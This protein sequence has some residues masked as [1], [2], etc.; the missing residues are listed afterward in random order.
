MVFITNWLN[1]I[2][3]QCISTSNGPVTGNT[4]ISWPLLGLT[5]TWIW[6]LGFH[7]GCCAQNRECLPFMNTCIHSCFITEFVDSVFCSFCFRFTF[8]FFVFVLSFSLFHICLVSLDYALLISR[9][10]ILHWINHE[11][12]LHKYM[13][14]LWPRIMLLMKSSNTAPKNSIICV[15]VHSG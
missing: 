7:D 13:N 3:Y 4:I 9:M 1:H 10:G 6:D 8:K 14:Y 2:V 12:A 5:Y 15:I 11:Q